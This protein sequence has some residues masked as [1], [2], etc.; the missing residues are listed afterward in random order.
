MSAQFWWACKRGQKR[1]KL[2]LFSVNLEQVSK[3]TISGFSLLIWIWFWNEQKNENSCPFLNAFK[4]LITFWFGQKT[5]LWTKLAKN[6]QKLT[7]NGQFE[8]DW[9]RMNIHK[10]TTKY[11]LDLNPSLSVILNLLVILTEKLFRVQFRK[12]WTCDKMTRNND[13][14]KKY[15]FGEIRWKVNEI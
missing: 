2:W 11:R 1:K 7:E 5:K 15:I 12:I 10:S 8:T 4:S 3:Q 6:G 9:T 13:V 14:M